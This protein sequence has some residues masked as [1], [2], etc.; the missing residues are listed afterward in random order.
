VNR[1]SAGLTNVR[2]RTERKNEAAKSKHPLPGPVAARSKG[3]GGMN[4]QL[5]GNGFAIYASRAGPYVVVRDCMTAT[6]EA[7]QLYGPLQL[8]EHVWPED[9]RV[10]G[11]VDAVAAQIDDHLFA[12]LEDLSNVGGCEPRGSGAKR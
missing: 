3:R 12:V 9:F 8:R 1:S 4:A 7:E 2:Y 10:P 6:L 11:L 5:N